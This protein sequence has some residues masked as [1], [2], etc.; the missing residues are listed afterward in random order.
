MASTTLVT[1]PT[2]QFF[3]DSTELTTPV[4][5]YSQHI[6]NLC[7]P[8]FQK[9]ILDI[10]ELYDFSDQNKA[11]FEAEL[12]MLQFSQES[13]EF[14]EHIVQITETSM[15]IF[16]NRLEMIETPDQPLV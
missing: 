13:A 5:D 7:P 1:P 9:Y 10:P 4:A 2:R 12:V 11:L 6:E 8:G 3:E 16:S 14:N 15:R